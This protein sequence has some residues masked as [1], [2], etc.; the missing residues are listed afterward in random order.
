M[1]KKDKNQNDTLD[2]N[3]EEV[4]LNF[5]YLFFDNVTLTKNTIRFEGCLISIV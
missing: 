2:Q 5:R 3:I 4:T 1:K